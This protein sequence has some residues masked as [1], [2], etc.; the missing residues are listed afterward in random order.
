[1]L[2]P[3]MGYV[4]CNSTV[5]VVRHDGFDLLRGAQRWVLDGVAIMEQGVGYEEYTLLS[6]LKVLA[7]AKCINCL[8]PKTGWKATEASQ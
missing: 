6:L 4:H 1:M 7:E 8:C 3:L 5:L 2:C